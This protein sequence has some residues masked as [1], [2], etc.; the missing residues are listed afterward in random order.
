MVF[1]K[2]DNIGADPIVGHFSLQNFFSKHLLAQLCSI[3]LQR[4][5]ALRQGRMRVVIRRVTMSH[6]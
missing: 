2:Q 3:N 5:Q 6:H 1:D 4:L